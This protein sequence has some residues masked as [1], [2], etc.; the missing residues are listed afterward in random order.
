MIQTERLNLVPLTHAQLLKYIK[1]DNSLEEELHLNPT[2]R[3]ISRN[4]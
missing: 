4:S 2:T 1:A 3:Q